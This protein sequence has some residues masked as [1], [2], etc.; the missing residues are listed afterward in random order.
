MAPGPHPS[1]PSRRVR[2]V[3][4]RCCCC[5]GGG[6]CPLP[7][8]AQAR[9]AAG[10]AACGRRDSAARRGRLCALRAG[11]S[12]R[13]RG[14][15]RG[16]EGP[17]PVPA[18]PGALPACRSHAGFG[19]VQFGAKNR[20]CGRRTRK[21]CTIGRRPGAQGAPG[22]RGR[23]APT[24][25]AAVADAQAAEAGERRAELEAG[26][27]SP[28]TCGC[29]LPRRG[30]ECRECT[31][32]ASWCARQTQGRATPSASFATTTAQGGWFP[33]LW[34]SRRLEDQQPWPAA[35]TSSRVRVRVRRVM[36][37]LSQ[38]LVCAN[39]TAMTTPRA[40][41]ATGL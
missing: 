21:L 40:G 19:R 32:T 6:G 22:R 25:R 34:G 11:P 14:H 31:A 28:R 20:T 13:R 10:A 29:K 23:A 35:V 27:G 7:C 4:R 5:R 16:A 12:R 36:V 30:A 17:A 37:S 15:R 9:R 38:F 26:T 39:D 18:P 3:R 8:P 2:R 1:P 24:R 41:S 33:P